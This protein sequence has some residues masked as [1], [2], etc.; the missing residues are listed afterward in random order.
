MSR[1]FTVI[2]APQRSEAWTMARL[3][4]LTGSRA[5]DML[6]TR[7]DGKEAA[8]RTNLRVQL[9]LERVTGQPQERHF[10]SAA[11]QYGSE[12]E[13]EAYAAYEALT[14]TMLKRTGFLSH[15]GLMVGCSLDGHTGDFEGLIEIKCPIPA[16]HLDYVRTGVIPGEYLKQITHAL[17]VSGAEWCDWMSYERTFPEHLRAKL[18]RV[19]REDVDIEAYKKQAMAFLAEVDREVEAVHTMTDVTSVLRKVVA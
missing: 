1:Q 12:M 13:P 5:S 6:A 7:K 10:Q 3:G 18:V 14:G 16:T 11:M 9:V 4:R 19:R 15:S 8:G 2:D 17:W